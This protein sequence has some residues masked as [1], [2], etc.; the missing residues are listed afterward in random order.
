MLVKFG[1]TV[2]NQLVFLHRTHRMVSNKEDSLVV[3][4]FLRAV[5]ER[6]GML[7]TKWFMSDDAD[8]AWR[9]TFGDQQTRKLL[10]AWH[11]DRG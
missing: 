1:T 9:A 8:T 11:V 7:N 5:K 6:C 2:C 10:C 3:V 4:E